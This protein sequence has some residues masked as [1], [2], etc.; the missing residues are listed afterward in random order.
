MGTSSAYLDEN[1]RGADCHEA[2]KL[3]E[4]IVFVTLGR[5]V[6]VHLR[7]ALDSELLLLESHGVRVGREALSILNDSVWKGGREEQHLYV[8]RKHAV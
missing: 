8:F 6:H 1:D 4:N 5:A 3:H 2:V 7:N